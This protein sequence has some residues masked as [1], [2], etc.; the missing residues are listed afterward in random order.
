MS[1]CP[2]HPDAFLDGVQ[3]ALQEANNALQQC[4]DLDG[5][6]IRLEALLQ[7]LL[8]VEPVFSPSVNYS[9]LLAAVSDMIA[10]G[11][12]EMVERNDLRSRGRPQLRICESALSNLLEQEF[13]QVEIAKVLGC[14]AKTVHR[15]IVQYGLSRFIQ[16]TD[17]SDAEL[18]G[19]VQDFVA[20]F[21]TAGQ[22]T[23]AG[24]LSSLGYRVKRLRIRESLY[25]VDPWGVE[26]RSRQL[27]HRRKYKVAGPNSL[28]HIDGNHKLIRWR[29]VIHGGI[30]GYSRIPVYL[31]ASVNNR[32]ETVVQHF[33]EAVGT[34]G[35]PSRVRADKGGENT[36]VSEYMLRHPH[37]GPGRGSFIT[38]RSVH[39]QRIERLWRDVSSSCTMHLYHLF[40]SLEDEGLLD[41]VDEVDLFSLHWVFIPRLNQQLQSFRSAYA[42]HKLRTEH[43]HTPLQLW[44]RGILATQDVAAL[45]GL[46]VMSEVSFLGGGVDLV[47]NDQQWLQ[48]LPKML[49]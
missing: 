4:G 47:M 44:T 6:L 26:R 48:S 19:L 33:L 34:Y 29:I 21:P 38:G 2:I 18:D 14:S 13:T 15:R 9:N 10:C 22:V 46:D 40:Y 31:A 45:N 30:D 32:S 49:E 27:L 8:W 16:Y 12:S 17:L 36:L 41:P 37:R 20:N 11:Y 3:V 24:H 25:R 42:H 39:N 28:W 43:S 1:E 23:L 35:L 5:V 7:S